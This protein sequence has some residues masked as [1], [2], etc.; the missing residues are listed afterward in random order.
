MDKEVQHRLDVDTSHHDQTTKEFALNGIGRA[1]LRTTVPML[2]DPYSKNRA[3]GSFVLI[4]EPTGVAG[5]AG[6]IIAGS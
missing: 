2:C 5:G 4:G 1:Q 3:T 6:M